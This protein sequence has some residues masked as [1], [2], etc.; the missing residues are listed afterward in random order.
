MNGIISDTEKSFSLFNTKLASTIVLSV[1]LFSGFAVGMNVKPDAIS[2]FGFLGTREISYEKLSWIS[3]EKAPSFR[4]KNTEI[5]AE[6]SEIKFLPFIFEKHTVAKK[7]KIPKS[8]FQAKATN[9][10]KLA[11]TVKLMTETKSD[12]YDDFRTAA[13][14]LRGEFFSATSSVPQV[15]KTSLEIVQSS[16]E[17]K[18]LNSK[19]VT[20]EGVVDTG[21]SQ[22]SSDDLNTVS[23]RTRETKISSELTPAE[24]KALTESLL[25]FQ[26]ST[27]NREFTGSNGMKVVQIEIA[28]SRIT[29]SK[30]NNAA[31]TSKR[32]SV[33]LRDAKRV[34]TQFGDE[35]P[36]NQSV[37]VEA[38]KRNINT[39]PV[40]AERICDVSNHTFSKPNKTELDTQI[41]VA[42]KTWIS[43]S[44]N[45]SGWLRA[46]ANQYLPTVTLHPAPNGGDTL[47]LDENSLALV[48][49]KSGIR[50][51]KGAGTV[52]G[53]LPEG[54]KV[55]FLGRSEDTE[56]FESNGKKYFAILNVEPGAGVLELQPQSGQDQ[57]STVFTPV[58]EDTVTYL[59]LAKPTLQK[60]AIKVVK[61]NLENDPEVSGLSVGL[62]TQSGI[63][64]ITQSS[65][66]TVLKNVNLVNGFPIFIDISSKQDQTAGYTYRYE[67]KQ[68]NSLGEYVV[69]QVS[70]K[71]IHHWIRQLKQNL[72]EQSAMVVGIYDRNRLGG[73]SSN[74]FSRVESLSD[75]YGLEPINF[76]VLWDGKISQ[77]EPLEGDVPRFM[78]VQIPEGLS[79]IKLINES[80]Q[81]VESNLMPISPRVIHVVSE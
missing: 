62:S 40:E 16:R 70:E 24:Q 26:L 72:N 31:A 81:V 19:T 55:E 30:L 66:R 5:V 3:D 13:L 76:T 15:D 37:R 78:A 60:I 29:P 48:A 47:L 75:K 18:N 79:Q 11:E 64:A 43:K 58:F 56:Y 67:L 8:F 57:S 41:D 12:Q 20:A 74:F 45:C 34:P 17:E 65:G 21:S 61:S 6:N 44:W 32:S 33:Q 42:K 14:N 4:P 49:V 28:K 7:R 27:Q 9:L 38:I 53:L 50:I 10:E 1:C 52:L 51:A 54:Y 63:Q 77:S 25:N 35:R 36:Q 39:S 59:D 68:K 80:N 69:N 23:K 73:F 2:K 22:I 46:E 71:T